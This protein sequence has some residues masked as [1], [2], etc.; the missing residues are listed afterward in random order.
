MGNYIDYDQG[1]V[2]N[3]FDNIMDILQPLTKSTACI[4]LKGLWET[5]LLGD[6]YSFRYMF[7][8]QIHPYFNDFLT[9]QL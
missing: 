9:I 2:Y 5:K 4:F 8:D 1:D 3:K 6:F 7:F